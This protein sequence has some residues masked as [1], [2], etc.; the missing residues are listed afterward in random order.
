MQAE[1]VA[2]EGLCGPA[3][4]AAVQAPADD[5]ATGHAAG[6]NNN[7]NWVSSIGF[8]SAARIGH[9]CRQAVRRRETMPS[10][11]TSSDTDIVGRGRRLCGESRNHGRY[12][13]HPMRPIRIHLDDDV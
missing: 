11:D 5:A 12:L 13:L 10:D 2:G 7:I 6:T 9:R 8:V 1:Q 3:D 4:D